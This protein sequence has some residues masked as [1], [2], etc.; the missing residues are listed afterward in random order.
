M[1][2]VA[3]YCLVGVPM[4]GA[5]VGSLGSSF[6]TI[7]FRRTDET[8][9]ST[10]DMYSREVCV[11][12]SFASPFSLFL[13]RFLSSSSIFASLL[14]TGL[15]FN[16]SPLFSSRLLSS[17]FSLSLSLFRFLIAHAPSLRRSFPYFRPGLH[18]TAAA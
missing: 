4:F 14:S 1:G 7:I 6:F 18:S 3:L 15:S 8:P 12:L 10:L 13:Y 17:L 11:S 16:L 5:F 9:L 2:F